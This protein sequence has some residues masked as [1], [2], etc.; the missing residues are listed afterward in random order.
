M[1]EKAKDLECDILGLFSFQV[2]HSYWQK[3]TLRFILHKTNFRINSFR[4]GWIQGLSI[5]SFVVS[6]H[7]SALLHSQLYSF[8]TVAQTITNVSEFEFYLFSN[9]SRTRASLS[10]FH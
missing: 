2:L 6:L 7:L 10:Q 4:H 1:G 3:S 9:P 8:P 5:K